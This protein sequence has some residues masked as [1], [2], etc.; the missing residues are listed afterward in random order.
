MSRRVCL[1][2]ECAL[3]AIFAPTFGSQ[4]PHLPLVVD[5]QPSR[6][7]Q[8]KLAEPEVFFLWVSEGRG[9][10]QAVPS[11]SVLDKKSTFFCQFSF[12]IG[13]FVRL[14]CN[15]TKK[16]YRYVQKTTSVCL[17]CY[18]ICFVW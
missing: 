13:I 2:G 1:E 11:E 5:R 17:G 15:L 6:A 18:H 4:I 7:R 10:L 9:C 3:R 14:M 8:T 12:I 16:Q